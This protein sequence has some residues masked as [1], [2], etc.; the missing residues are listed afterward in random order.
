MCVRF[1]HRGLPLVSLHK[2]NKGSSFSGLH[3]SSVDEQERFI[4]VL[5]HRQFQNARTKKK[6]DPHSIAIL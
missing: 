4:F 2:G 1:L 3:L 5:E 6:L